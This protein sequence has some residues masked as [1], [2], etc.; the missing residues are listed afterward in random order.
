MDRTRMW[1]E[2][3]KL[4]LKKGGLWNNSQQDD[5]ARYW[6]ILRREKTAG[7]ELGK[8]ACETKVKAFHPSPA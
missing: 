2:A 5:L 3:L 1:K 6:K 7:K 8:N 4:T